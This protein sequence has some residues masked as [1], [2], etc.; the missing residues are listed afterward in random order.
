MAVTSSIDCVLR[1]WDLEKGAQAGEIKAGPG[2]VRTLVGLRACALCTVRELRGRMEA[3]FIRPPHRPNIDFTPTTTTTI[4]V[5]S[6]AW[7]P[8][9]A[10]VA[11]GSQSGKVNL[12]DVSNRANPVLAVLDTNAVARFVYSVAFVSPSSLRVVGPPHTL[13]MMSGSMAI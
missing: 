8:V 1:L 2:E 4:Q 6:A 13:G 3:F 11:S 10:L 5:W 12:W 9:A 7:S